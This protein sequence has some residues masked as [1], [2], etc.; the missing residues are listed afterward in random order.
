MGSKRNPSKRRIIRPTFFVFCEGETEEMYVKHL[1]S[2]YKVSI[3]IDP[4][5]SGNRVTDK[6]IRNYKKDRFT[7]KSDL[8]FLLYDLDVPTMLAKL[9]GI[10]ST[11]VLASNPCIELWF[12]LH[13]KEQNAH[14]ATKKC[15]RDLTGKFKN[16]KKGVIDKALKGTLDSGEA[17]AVNRAKKQTQY[18]NPSSTVYKLIEELRKVQR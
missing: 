5:I 18:N 8:T 12:S 15:I 13:Y 14:I 3:Q 1:R 4:K 9:Q 16:Y 10:K 11:I 2:K 17:K 7:D 6:Y